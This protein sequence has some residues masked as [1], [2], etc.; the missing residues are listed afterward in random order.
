MEA[1]EGRMGLVA[2][3]ILDMDGAGEVEA[4]T[5]IGGLSMTED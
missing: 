5:T 2:A 1:E 3:A 4:D